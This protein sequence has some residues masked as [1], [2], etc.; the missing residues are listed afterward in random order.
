MK[1]WNG[2]FKNNEVTLK[3]THAK[4]YCKMNCSSLFGFTPTE[5]TL[6]YWFHV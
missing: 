2:D 3:C 4:R 1:N 6:K 5:Y